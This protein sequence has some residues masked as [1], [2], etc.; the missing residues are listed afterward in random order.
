MAWNVFWRLGV[1]FVRDYDEARY[2]VAASEMLHH[3]SMLVTTYAGATEFWRSDAPTPSPPGSSNKKLARS[4]PW[5]SILC[6]SKTS[7]DA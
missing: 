3:H 7:S 2:G 1:A 6:S 5:I 4:L